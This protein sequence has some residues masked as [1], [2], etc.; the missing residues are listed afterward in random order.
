LPPS[1]SVERLFRL[2]GQTFKPTR[3]RLSDERI[4]QF[5]V[6]L[7]MSQN[8]Q[9]SILYVHR[10]NNAKMPSEQQPVLIV[11]TSTTTK[12]IK[13]KLA[14]VDGVASSYVHVKAATVGS[15]IA[16]EDEQ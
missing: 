5:I 2:G 7:K 16:E 12:T 8:I 9:Y 14:L 15:R 4:E 10:K 6:F 11:N 3:N 1:A 13:T